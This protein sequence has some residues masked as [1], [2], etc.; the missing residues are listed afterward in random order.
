[1]I[2]DESYHLKSLLLRKLFTDYL[3]NSKNFFIAPTAA[4]KINDL[5]NNLKSSKNVGLIVSPLKS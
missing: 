3:K 2:D 5:I 4:D 1:M